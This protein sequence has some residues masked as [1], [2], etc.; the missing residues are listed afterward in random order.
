MEQH[1]PEVQGQ[2]GEPDSASN[3]NSAELEPGRTFR[4]LGVG[5]SNFGEDSEAGEPQE[6]QLPLFAGE[7][8]F[9]PEAGTV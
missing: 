8:A 3:H 2:V 4:L 7:D 6:Q 1:T 9:P 5:V